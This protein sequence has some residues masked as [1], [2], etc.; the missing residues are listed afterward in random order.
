MGRIIPLVH[1]PVFVGAK[2]ARTLTL[3]TSKDEYDSDPST[4]AKKDWTGYTATMAVRSRE[5]DATAIVELSTVNG[6]IVLG[7]TAGTITLTLDDSVTAAIDPQVGVFDFVPN[8]GTDQLE[9]LFRG[10][11]EF[12]HSST[13]Q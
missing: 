12:I 7:G 13:L 3:Y 2:W 11:L 1:W 5:A 6:R 8:D 10:Q 4:A 9:P